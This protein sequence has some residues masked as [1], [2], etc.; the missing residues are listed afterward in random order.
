MLVDPTIDITLPVPPITNTMYRTTRN[1][2]VYKKPEVKKYQETVKKICVEKKLVP[3]LGPVKVDL[4][5]YRGKKVGDL[6]GRIKIILDALQGHAYEND[7]QI[8]DLHAWLVDGEAPK[9]LV[10]VQSWKI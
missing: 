2:I 3:I 4:L 5:W 7:K 6:D 1:G 8:V 10:G 9:M